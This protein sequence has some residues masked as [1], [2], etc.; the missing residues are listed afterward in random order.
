LAGFFS[1]NTILPKNRS[2]FYVFK[3]VLLSKFRIK[4]K[5]KDSS[6]GILWSL[7]N[8]LLYM[9][10]L[11]LVF[12]KL[13]ERTIENFP[14]YLLTG[15]LLFDF[16]SSSTTASMNSVIQAASLIKRVYF[17]KYIITLSKIISNF[18]FLLISLVVLALIMAFT[19]APVTV[20]ILFAPIY[21]LLQ[22][23]FC[24]GMGLLLATVTVFFRDVQHLYSVLTT[25]LMFASAIF[26]PAEII[27][28]KFHFI[29]D[30]NPLFHFIDGF[31]TVVYHGLPAE[32]LNLLICASLALV[33]MIAGI[34]VFERSQDKFIL[35]I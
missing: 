5:Y 22:F 31:R 25:M 19:R 4:K 26:Y 3:R 9:I 15:R 24:C 2:P 33:S 35:Y 29:L 18:I 21:L 17:P 8:P 6:L 7:L 32:P 11:T 13:F 30:L 28:D 12:S 23:F 27:P 14:V 1:S 34:V 20:N 10:V 16:F